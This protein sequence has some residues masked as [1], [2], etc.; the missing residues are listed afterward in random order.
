MATHRTNHR[1]WY[2][3]NWPKVAPFLDRNFIREFQQE[4]SH[5]QRAWEFHLAVV[6]QKSGVELMPT[7]SHGPDFLFESNGKRIWIEAVT[8]SRGT[9][10]AVEPYPEMVSGRFYSFGGDI[11]TTQRPRVLRI[12]NAITEKRNKFQE[13][14]SDPRSNVRQGDCLVIAINGNAIQHHTSDGALFQRAVF[15]R[16]NYVYKYKGDG[17]ALDGPYYQEEPVVVKN[18]EK[19]PVTVATD[20]L[21]SPDYEQISAIMYC[22]HTA[23]Y[24]WYNDLQLGDDIFIGHHALAKNP[25]PEDTFGFGVSITKNPATTAITERSSKPLPPPR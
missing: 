21:T 3:D 10:D 20:I 2:E 22:G 11:Q 9:A 1:A 17:E 8:C 15:A 6:L 13:Y 12:T 4:A 24:G 14:L 7:S 16:G 23:S 19:G 18:T 5:A 25:V